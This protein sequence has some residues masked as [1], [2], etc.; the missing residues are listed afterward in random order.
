MVRR[1][2]DAPVEG[3][4]RRDDHRRSGLGGRRC[5]EHAA[6]QNRQ[7]GE[8]DG[9]DVPSAGELEHESSVG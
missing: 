5:G 2:E 8:T 6:Q 1:A 3:L 7:C 4:E 9:P